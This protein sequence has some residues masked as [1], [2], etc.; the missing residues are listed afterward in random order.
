M[1]ITS[2][3]VNFV[4]TSSDT[5]NLPSSSSELR[6]TF[7]F[8]FGWRGFIRKRAI[9]SPFFKKGLFGTAFSWLDKAVRSDDSSRSLS[10]SSVLKSLWTVA[11]SIYNNRRAIDD[12]LLKKYRVSIELYRHYQELYTYI[13][14]DS[15]SVSLVREESSFSTMNSHVSALSHSFESSTNRILWS[16]H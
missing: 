3:R 12:I 13:L 9:P 10:L 1:L 6:P 16:V 4:W 14:T 7:A 2:S 15:I 8:L 5:E 11:I